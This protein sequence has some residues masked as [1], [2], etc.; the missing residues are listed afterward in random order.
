MDDDGSRSLD[1]KEFQKG[2]HDYGL[3]IETVE[4]QEIFKQLDKDGSGSLDFDEFLIALRVCMIIAF[5]TKDFIT[6]L[7]LAHLSKKFSE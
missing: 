1:I 6:P 3:L 5:Y 2:I 7:F 4:S